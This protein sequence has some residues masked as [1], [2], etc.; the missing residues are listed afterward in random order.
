[1]KLTYVINFLLQE[2]KVRIIISM[3]YAD[4]SRLIMCAVSKKV[5]PHPDS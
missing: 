2:R 1:M 3:M 5:S 4:K